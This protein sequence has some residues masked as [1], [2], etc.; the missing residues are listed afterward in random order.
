[1]D[2]LLL[3]DSCSSCSSSSSSVS[4]RAK[5]NYLRGKYKEEGNSC[6]YVLSPLVSPWDIILSVTVSWWGLRFHTLHLASRGCLLRVNYM[7]I[8]HKTLVCSRLT[9]VSLSAVA[10]WPE[11]DLKSLRGSL[12][13]CCVME[14]DVWPSEPAGLLLCVHWCPNA[15]S[16]GPTHSSLVLHKGKKTYQI[17][18]RTLCTVLII[19]SV[20]GVDELYS[21]MF[22]RSHNESVYFS[23][24]FN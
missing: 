2:L 14:A 24:K 22:Y 11:R 8:Q 12:S 20:T 17:S 6:K 4:C 1:M 3:G 19:T 9:N 18:Q 7:P 16:Q 10:G 21:W 5:T 13:V 15:Q 23:F